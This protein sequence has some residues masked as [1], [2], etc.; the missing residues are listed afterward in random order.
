MH[1][2]IAVT[3]V[4]LGVAVLAGAPRALAQDT[5]LPSR[6]L[7]RAGD[8]NRSLPR[9]DCFALY[10]TDGFAAASGL[11]EL[12]RVSGPF[13]IAV[14]ADGH[15]R[16]ALTFDVEGLPPADTTGDG[17][18]YVAWVT[19]PTFS[20]TIKLGPV[21]NARVRLG[22]ARFNKFT[23]LVT[24]EASADVTERAGPLVLRGR[25]PS[26]LMETHDLLAQAP[27]AFDGGAGEMARRTDTVTA[28]AWRMPPMHTAVPMLPGMRRLVPRGA[29]F[30]PSV[31]PASVPEASPRQVVRLGNGGTLDL[32]AG[33]GP[34]SRPGR[35][36]T[37][38]RAA[39]HASE[40][41]SVTRSD[42]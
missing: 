15:I 9:L 6:C 34:E 35:R 33:P 28:D 3:L 39:P 21:D 19:T 24:L 13:G 30:L 10:P 42:S 29:P 12:G 5:G 8:R 23:I 18:V 22:E 11:V 38:C 7:P 2:R 20:P 26:S 16:Q 1:L 31:D 32:E 36:R 25:S 17:S 37:G 41:P 14:T 27:S 40:S 4:G